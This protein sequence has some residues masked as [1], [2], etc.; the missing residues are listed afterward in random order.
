VQET[1]EIQKNLYIYENKHDRC[2][3]IKGSSWDVNTR[4][5]VVWIISKTR[6]YTDS[7]ILRGTLARQ[8]LTFIQRHIA[9]MLCLTKYHVVILLLILTCAWVAVLLIEE[10]R[11]RSEHRYAY[12]TTQIFSLDPPNL[13][14]V[15][16]SNPARRSK[17]TNSTNHRYAYLQPS[18]MVLG[19]KSIGFFD[20]TRFYYNLVFEHSSIWKSWL[21][22][23]LSDDPILEQN[24]RDWQEESHMI[25]SFP[26][27]WALNISQNE[28]ETSWKEIPCI[29]WSKF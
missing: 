11:D 15:S 28:S 22:I 13:A 17:R 16:G 20:F 10:Y 14:L 8:L 12:C 24:F 6:N 18:Q 26:P 5:C 25:S 21:V 19:S 1:S 29:N 27:N 4:T 2:I 9:N 7:W 3:I 23:N